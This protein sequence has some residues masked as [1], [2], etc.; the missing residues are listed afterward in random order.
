MMKIHPL[1]P[2]VLIALLAFAVLAAAAARG[3]GVK[4]YDFPGRYEKKSAQGFAVYRDF[5]FLCNDTGHCR[6]YNLKTSQKIAGFALASAAKTN[7]ANCASFGV[8]FPK[9]NKTFPAFYVSECRSPF[10]CFVESIDETGSRLVQT[11]QLKTGGPDER[12]FD[13]VVDRGQKC[14]YALALI[15][16]TKDTPQNII[17]TRLP[18]PPLNKAEV[19][20][21]KND[22]LDQFTVSFPNLT[23]GATVRDGFLY[24]PVGLHD[25]AKGTKEWRSREIIVIDLKTK[26]I[27]RRIDLNASVPEEPE[28]ADFHGD[29]LLLYCGQKG[30][31][32]KINTE[33]AA[34]ARDL[35]DLA[36][37]Q[38]QFAALQYD[39]LLAAM[40]RENPDREP[41][42]VRDG[43]LRTVKPTG[44]TSGFFPGSLWLIYEQTKDP[45]FRAAAEDYTRRLEP[46]QNFTGNH[47]VGFML[48]CSYGE[49]WRV[50]RDPAYRAVL[51]QGARS[52]ATR[53]SP[54]VGLIRSW[55]NPKWKYPVIVDN[56]MNLGLLWFAGAET[57]EKTFHD[58]VT[59]HA[60][61]TLANHFRADSSSFHLVEYNPDTGAVQKRQTVQ[62]HADD[63][64]WSRGQAWGLAGYAAA[65]RYAGNPAYRA[66]AE[67]IARF[68][69]NHPR[70]PAD[71][72][73][74]WD[75]DAPGIPESAPRDASAAAVT[76]LGLLDLAQQLGPEQG[77]PCRAFAEKQLRSLAT[78]AY[79]ARLGENG[80]FL[81]MHSVTSLPGNSE[82][83]VP[84][85]YADYYFL[86]ALSVVLGGGFSET[87]VP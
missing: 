61:K 68:I 4:E 84:L 12:V 50:T 14:L 21:E 87:G 2:S 6:I 32:Y 62:G 48:G 18:L 76:A 13:W 1:H 34:A 37:E 69:I 81:L 86:K 33:S 35:R 42:S 11:L 15:K 17:I 41:H 52:L 24:M 83:D 64:A 54:K 72:I 30:G 80:H 16:G 3:G 65:A 44:W 49:G 26:K 55:N 8:E 78:P 39:S 47:D 5:A 10:R 7:H 71:G 57:G 73:P 27:Q 40:R 45:R 75:Y 79:R 53:F 20:F 85:V 60:D 25:I 46:I 29:T 19:N 38:F 82:I 58:I 59:N 63:S 9:G 66:Q 67:K 31:L 36:R 56:M 22:I 43:K 70:M 77:A 51:I 23:Q 28:D 74:Y